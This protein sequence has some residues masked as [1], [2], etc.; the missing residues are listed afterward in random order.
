MRLIL[1]LVVPLLCAACGSDTPTSPSTTPTTTSTVA[2][3]TIS[4]TY[5]STLSIAGSKFY[6]FPVVQNGTVNVTLT[7]LSGPDITEDMTVDLGLGRP[8]GFGCTPASTVTVSTLT[9]GTADYRHLR[10]R[11]V[12]RAHRGHGRHSTGGRSILHFHRALVIA[13]RFLLLAVLL[14]A[15]CDDT[16][17]GPSA[18]TPEQL[19]DDIDAD[20]RVVRGDA[21]A[22]RVDVLFL[23][24]DDDRA[25][26]RRRLPRWSSRGR[27]RAGNA[28]ANRVRNT[29]WR[30]L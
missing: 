14:G 11:R 26:R 9:G 3:A 21:V 6:S 1:A 20:H 5:S 2:P 19:H 4:E 15:A 17:S 8:S 18:Q 28:A 13:K 22:R 27:L 30:R 12:L 23:Q 16:I 7:S 29:G 10:T 24:R 25:R